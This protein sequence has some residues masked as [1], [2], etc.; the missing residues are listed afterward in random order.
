VTQ[1]SSHKEGWNWAGRT[2]Y[3]KEHLPSK[4]EALS[5]NP[6]TAKKKKK[7]GTKCTVFLEAKEGGECASGAVVSRTGVCVRAWE[8]HALTH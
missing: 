6:R 1:Y 3:V 4:R 8:G 7:A 2:I 5:S